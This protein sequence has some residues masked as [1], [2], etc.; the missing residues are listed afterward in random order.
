MRGERRL[1]STFRENKIVWKSK[2]SMCQVIQNLKRVVLKKEVEVRNRWEEYF[3]GLLN[4]R[5]VREV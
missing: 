1:V 4:V 5:D 2:G 3:E